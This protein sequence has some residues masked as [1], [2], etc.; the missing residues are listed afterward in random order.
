MLRNTFFAQNQSAGS[1]TITFRDGEEVEAEDLATD[2]VDASELPVDLLRTGNKLI[3]RSPIAGAG[4]HDI[5]VTITP[6][7]LTI[8]KNSWQGRSEEKEHFYLQECHW[9]NLSRTVDLP[10]PIDP[11]RTRASL[12]NGILTIIMPLASTSHTKIIQIQDDS[13]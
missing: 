10:K 2:S 7:Q 1:K 4:I 8:N 6:N 11:D 13:R 12:N 5:S 3:A 9:G